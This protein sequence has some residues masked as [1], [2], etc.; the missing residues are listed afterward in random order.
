MF[1]LWQCLKEKKKKKQLISFVKI[2][3]PQYSRKIHPISGVYF[4]TLTVGGTHSAMS[5]RKYTPEKGYPGFFIV[6]LNH[7]VIFNRFKKHQ[8]HTL[9]VISFYQKIIQM[10]EFYQFQEVLLI[11]LTIGSFQF[12]YGKYTYEVISTY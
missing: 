9:F 5:R 6:S 7:W 12:L 10:F 2:V 3:Q 8:Q 4:L 1:L 11:N